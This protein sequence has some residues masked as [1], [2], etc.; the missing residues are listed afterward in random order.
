MAAVTSRKNREYTFN[1]S[2][3]ANIRAW[4]NIHIGICNVESR[5]KAF[6]KAKAQEFEKKNNALLDTL[7]R[8][9]W[10]VHL[11]TTTN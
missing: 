1:C 5:K 7:T 9:A 3:T 2:V 10:C 8:A 4:Q 6:G 11:Y